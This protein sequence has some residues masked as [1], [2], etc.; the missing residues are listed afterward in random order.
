MT[1]MIVVALIVVCLV[2]A[3]SNRGGRAPIARRPALDDEDEGS[4]IERGIVTK[5]TGVTHDNLDGSSRQAIIARCQDGDALLLRREPHN[6]FDRNAIA[7]FT[8]GGAQIGYLPRDCAARLQ[9][10]VRHARNDVR[11]RILSVTGGVPEKPTRGVNIAINL[12]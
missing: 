8:V 1:A 12:G 7:V 3:L 9:P 5:I 11:V 10:T 2:A 6:P 4:E